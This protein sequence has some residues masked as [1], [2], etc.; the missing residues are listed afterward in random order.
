M[1]R[2]LQQA[3]VALAPAP[4][5]YLTL[6]G[7]PGLQGP[8]LSPSVMIPVATDDTVLAVQPNEGSVPSLCW[9]SQANC[10]LCVP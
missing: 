4:A 2:S 3:S 10:F 9:P 6:P 1:R 8:V 5:Y 7:A